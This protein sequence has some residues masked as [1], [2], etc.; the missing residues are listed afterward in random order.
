VTGRTRHRH[1]V[2]RG[3]P[4]HVPFVRIDSNRRRLEATET[5]NSG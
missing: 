2:A 4:S 3:E 5:V 1:R